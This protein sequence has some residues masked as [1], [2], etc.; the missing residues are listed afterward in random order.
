M[1]SLFPNPAVTPVGPSPSMGHSS[2]K[3]TLTRESLLSELKLAGT[4]F[5]VCKFSH[6]SVFSL[7]GKLKKTTGLLLFLISDFRLLP[8]FEHDPHLEIKIKVSVHI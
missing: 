7:N 2:G 3:L 4:L 5:L 6:L 8:P 1:T